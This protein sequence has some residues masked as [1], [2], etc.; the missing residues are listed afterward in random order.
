MGLAIS[1]I[2]VCCTSVKQLKTTKDQLRKGKVMLKRVCQ[3]LCLCAI[4]GLALT[5]CGDTSLGD[6]VSINLDPVAQV[7]KVEVTLSNG[8]EVNMSGD[9]PIANGYGTLSFVPATKTDNAKIVISF[10]LAQAI[11]DQMNGYGIR[12]QLPNGA[13]FPVAMTP[14]LF[15]IPVTQQG[16][17]TVDA[18]AAILPELQVGA[19]VGIPQFKSQYFPAGVSICQNFRDSNNYAYAAVCL[20]GP[21]AN[22]EPGGIFV[23]ADFG[24]VLDNNT[25][26]QSQQIASLQRSHN[27]LMSASVASEIQPLSDAQIVANINK[28]SWNWTEQKHDPKRQLS[29]LRGYKALQNAKKILSVKH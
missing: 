20:Y 10:D 6:N 29:G 8:L 18:L 2:R 13:P 19:L 24:Q 11:S 16:G 26:Q 27:A 4:G 14:P 7:A 17:I 15:D 12:N 1:L 22:N 23:G 28:K 21:G 5:G 9:F 25:I 3:S